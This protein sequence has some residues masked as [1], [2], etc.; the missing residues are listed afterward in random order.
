M[1]T[2]AGLQEVRSRFTRQ[3]ARIRA[4]HDTGASKA[5]WKIGLN[6]PDMQSRLGLQ[7]AVV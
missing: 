1:Q 7:G 4:Q 5:G 6:D 2:A 3:L